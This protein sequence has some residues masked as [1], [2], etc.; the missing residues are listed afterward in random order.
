MGFLRQEYWCGLPF[1]SPEDLLAPGIEPESLALAGGFFI[2]ELPG[3]PSHLLGD[4]RSPPRKT[5][6]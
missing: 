5:H 2:A 6:A 1:S 4:T 3:L